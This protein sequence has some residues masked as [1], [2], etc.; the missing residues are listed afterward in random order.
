MYDSARVCVFWLLLTAT[1][2]EPRVISSA[3]LQ[4]I[5]IQEVFKGA[6]SRGA[7]SKAKE[8]NISEAGLVRFPLPGKLVGEALGNGPHLRLR[9]KKLCI[10]GHSF[11]K[12]HVTIGCVSNPC[13][14]S[15]YWRR[16]RLLHYEGFRIPLPDLEEAG[17]YHTSSG[18]E[19]EEVVSRELVFLIIGTKTD[20]SVPVSPIPMW[21][22][23]CVKGFQSSSRVLVFNVE[24]RGHGIPSTA[25]S[26]S[27]G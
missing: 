4:F 3:A 13:H 26:A 2:V 19:H 10:P 24:K 12:L 23:L 22:S 25:M 17:P 9:S 7:K 15:D 8:V 11:P 27:A 18:P 14:L 21:S 20:L 5:L 6:W 1:A 16:S